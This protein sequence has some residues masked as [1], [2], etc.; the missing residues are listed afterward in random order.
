MRKEA[1]RDSDSQGN[2]SNTKQENTMT[3]EA[4]PEVKDITPFEMRFM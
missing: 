1:Y 3:Q 2:S 4:T